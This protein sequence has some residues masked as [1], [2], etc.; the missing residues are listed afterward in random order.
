ME[1]KIEKYGRVYSP[2][3]LIGDRY[4]DYTS[5]NDEL[6]GYKPRDFRD[7]L[8]ILGKTRQQPDEFFMLSKLRE[9]CDGSYAVE[10]SSERLKLFGFFEDYEPSIKDKFTI[11]MILE[12][13]LSLFG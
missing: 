6:N 2:N 4:H 5:V 10:G 1:G 12:S 13:A 11:N 3:D 9:Y 8:F 7:Q